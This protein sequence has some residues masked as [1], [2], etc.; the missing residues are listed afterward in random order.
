MPEEMRERPRQYLASRSEITAGDQIVLKHL[1]S[2][3]RLRQRFWLGI[4]LLLIGAGGALTLLARNG[5][6]CGAAGRTIGAFGAEYCAASARR[7]AS[8]FRALNGSPLCR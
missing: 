5:K 6:F 3:A 4:P 7:R 1:Q 8:L 2:T